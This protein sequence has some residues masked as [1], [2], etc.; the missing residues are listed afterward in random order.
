MSGEYDLLA[1]TTKHGSHWASDGEVTEGKTASG[2][3]TLALTPKALK[4]GALHMVLEPV[5]ENDAKIREFL[6]SA[7]YED[8]TL[9][10]LLEPALWGSLAVLF[11]WLAFTLPKDATHRR[12]DG[13]GQKDS[14]LCRPGFSIVEITALSTLG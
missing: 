9:T 13:E 2:E 14:C 6:R 4:A 8:Q 5:Q 3:A 11:F 1:V 10:R 12:R 7:I